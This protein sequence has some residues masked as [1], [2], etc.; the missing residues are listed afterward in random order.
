[1]SALTAGSTGGRNCERLAMLREDI[2]KALKD[3]MKAGD[4]R[5]VSTLRLVNAAI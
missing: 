3:A 5:R 1:M 2:N 4:K